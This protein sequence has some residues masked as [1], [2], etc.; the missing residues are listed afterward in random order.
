[1]SI[2]RRSREP[3]EHGGLSA[4]FARL[5]MQAQSLLREMRAWRI[6]LHRFRGRRHIP[7]SNASSEEQI[8]ENRVPSKPPSK[9]GSRSEAR[10]G[11][12]QRSS[13]DGKPVRCED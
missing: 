2:L 6:D 11:S 4:E 10:A 5:Q 8:P 13:G 3:G 7:A 12:E 1:M 9:A